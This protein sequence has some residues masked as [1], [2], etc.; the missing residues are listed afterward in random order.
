M[1]SRLEALVDDCTVLVTD[2]PRWASG[3]LVA[4]GLVLTDLTDLEPT[5]VEF[6]VRS[7]LDAIGVYVS[8]ISLEL[9]VRI[10]GDGHLADNFQRVAVVEIPQRDHPCIG[11]DLGFPG[12]DDP[13][14]I[15]G[16]G[17]VRRDVC[18]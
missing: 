15:V 12:E 3:A 6:T 10:H 7:S 11:L 2:G 9:S 5:S 4:P 1:T 18:R 8:D 17:H 16:W 13:L 14:L